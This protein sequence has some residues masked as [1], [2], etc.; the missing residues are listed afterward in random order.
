MTDPMVT[1]THCRSLGYCA[2]GMREFFQRHG[3]DWQ[4]F[5]ECGLPASVIEATGDG[6]AMRAARL[7][8]EE[9]K[10]ADDGRQQ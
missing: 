9:M 1:L 5:R 4:A 3:L 8:R 2:R 6:M 10:G 7:A